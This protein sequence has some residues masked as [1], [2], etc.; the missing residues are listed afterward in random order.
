MAAHFSLGES[1]AAR[2]KENVKCYKGRPEP[3][4]LAQLQIERQTRWHRASLCIVLSYLIIALLLLLMLS[5]SQSAAQED[6]LQRRLH[7]KDASVKKRVTSSD[8]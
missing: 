2:T 4:Q 3:E 7:R 8:R 6:G 1:S 5:S